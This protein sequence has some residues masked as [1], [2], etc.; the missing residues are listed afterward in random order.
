MEFYNDIYR[1]FYENFD[2]SDFIKLRLLNK[3]IDKLV[4]EIL[5]KNFSKVSNEKNYFLITSQTYKKIRIFPK[6]NY[7]LI[8]S[9]IYKRK[10]TKYEIETIVDIIKQLLKLIE[11]VGPKNKKYH[12][13][14]SI[15]I[16]IFNNMDLPKKY[17]KFY[18]DAINKSLQES[19]DLLSHLNKEDK[20]NI[21]ITFFEKIVKKCCNSMKHIKITK[22]SINKRYKKLENLEGED[23]KKTLNYLSKWKGMVH[24]LEIKIK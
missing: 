6:N 21:F 11:E 7:F 23:Y 4:C 24:E 17:S 19:F 14:E 1:C 8:M 9:R 12:I 10:Y 5:L 18:K 2:L 15:Y 13:M 3:K 20:R 22:D 16:L